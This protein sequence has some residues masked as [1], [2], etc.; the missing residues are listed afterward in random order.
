[1]LLPTILILPK[2]RLQSPFCSGV[3]QPTSLRSFAS[4]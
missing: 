3:F 4:S 2:I 1:M